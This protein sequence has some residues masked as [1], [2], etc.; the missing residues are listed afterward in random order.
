MQ[1]Q[2]TSITFRAIS[3]GTSTAFLKASLALSFSPCLQRA[4]PLLADSSRFL[5]IRKYSKRDSIYQTLHEFSETKHC[6]VFKFS[7]L[8]LVDSTSLLASNENPS[9]TMIGR[10]LLASN[11]SMYFIH[12]STY[13]KKESVEVKINLSLFRSY[14]KMSR[15]K[16]IFNSTHREVSIPKISSF[17][18]KMVAL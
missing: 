18:Q 16:I 8:L 5:L 11:T 17:A 10:T 9:K 7:H 3:F 4:N 6:F 13:L 12:N 15:W 14:S 1:L 2:H